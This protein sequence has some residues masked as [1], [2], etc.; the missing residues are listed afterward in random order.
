MSIHHRKSQDIEFIVDVFNKYTGKKVQ[1][2]SFTVWFEYI[3]Y[4]WEGDIAYEDDINE[5]AY[6]LD[7]KDLAEKINF[8]ED[9]TDYEFEIRTWNIA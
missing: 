6:S 2:A 1:E 7:N 3:P 4:D 9:Y 8:T 5:Y